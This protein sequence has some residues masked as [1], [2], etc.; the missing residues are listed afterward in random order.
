MNDPE[1][2]KEPQRADAVVNAVIGR[3]QNW[4]RRSDQEMQAHRREREASNLEAAVAE[5]RLHWNVPRRFLSQPKQHEEWQASLDVLSQRLGTGVMILLLGRHGTGKTQLCVELLKQVTAENRGGLYRTL[6]EFFS[7]LRSTYG[8]RGR[9]TEDEVMREH[10]A[11]SLLVLDEVGK[12]VDSNWEATVFFELI[13]RRYAAEKDTILSC[14]LDPDQVQDAI[15]SSILS[16]LQETGGIIQCD[17][18]SFRA[19]N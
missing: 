17:W 9:T 11:P 8:G 7:L 1:L 12:C 16:R 19:G 18:P 2:L 13:N 4:T 5:R 10:Q 6:T 3:M 14:N 15:D